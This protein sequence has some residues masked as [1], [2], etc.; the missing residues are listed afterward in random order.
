[1]ALIV[2]PQEHWEGLDIDARNGLAAQ[3]QELGVCI[4]TGEAS[5]REGDPGELTATTF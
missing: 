2:L 1:M 3:A 5:S 4:I